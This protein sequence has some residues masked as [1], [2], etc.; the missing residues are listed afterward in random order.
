MEAREL[1][2][3]DVILLEEGDKVP[4][5]ARLAEGGV[6]LSMLAGESM[7]AERIA[8]AGLHGAPLLEE[9]NLVFGGTTCVEGQARA[10]VFERAGKAAADLPTITLALA[11]GVRALA[12]RGALV[13]RLSA[14]ETLGSTSVICTDKTGTLTRNR[15]R[16]RTV[17]TPGHGAEPGPWSQELVHEAALCTAVTWDADGEP[18]GDPRSAGARRDG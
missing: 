13:K 9:P 18:H 2:P 16:L 14:V 1:V 11:V 3:G 8:A 12:R 6:D 17:W 7:P 10:V 15:M 5:D 4:A